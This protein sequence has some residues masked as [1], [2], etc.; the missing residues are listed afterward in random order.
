MVD[1]FRVPVQSAHELTDSA[2]V[3]NLQSEMQQAAVTPVLFD[4]R[5]YYFHDCEGGYA[6]ELDQ[7]IVTLL[8]TVQGDGNP[9]NDPAAPS[10][11]VHTPHS[12]VRLSVADIVHWGEAYPD[13][14]YGI[15]LYVDSHRQ[16]PYTFHD[17]LRQDIDGR[18]QEFS[19]NE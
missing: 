9:P 5:V 6:Q 16:G 18:K 4:D 15:C 3:A 10:V 11:E 8:H 17:E 19:Y 1:E 2:L 13:E 7:H 14:D 12:Y